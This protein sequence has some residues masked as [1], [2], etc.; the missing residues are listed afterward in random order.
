VLH[1]FAEG[2]VTEVAGMV[3]G[4][5]QGIEAA[6]QD[7]QDAGLGAEAVDLVVLLA[8]AGGDRAFEIAD[9][10]IGSLE[11]VGEGRQRVATSADQA[12]GAIVEHDVAGEDQGEGFGLNDRALGERLK[13][14]WRLL[15]SRL[16]GGCGQP[17][18]WLIL[19]APAFCSHQYCSSLSRTGS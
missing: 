1:G 17:A 2:F 3:V 15:A 14:W 6:L 11:N 5:G 13:G 18:F 7:G 19:S 10:V 4:Q 9:T 12:A 16:P 8:A